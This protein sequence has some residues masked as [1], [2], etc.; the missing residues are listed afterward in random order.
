MT[1]K[2]TYRTGHD[3]QG[4]YII[5]DAEVPECKR[6]WRNVAFIFDPDSENPLISISSPLGLNAIREIIDHAE[7]GLTFSRK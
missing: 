6:T 2:L 1:T 7:G 4:P 3:D 5:V